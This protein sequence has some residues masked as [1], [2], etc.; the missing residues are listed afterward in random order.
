MWGQRLMPG[1][2]LRLVPEN[3]GVTSSDKEGEADFHSVLYLS[4]QRAAGEVPP[5]LPASWKTTVSRSLLFALLQLSNP[6]WCGNQTVSVKCKH[7]CFLLLVLLLRVEYVTITPD[8]FRYRAQIFP[9]VNGLF[10]W[11]KDHYQEPVPGTETPSLSLFLSHQLGCG[12]HY[13][14]TTIFSFSGVT[15]SNSSRTR[16]PAS[17]NATPANINI[18]GAS[19]SAPDSDFLFLPLVNDVVS[20]CV[21]TCR[22]DAGGQRAASQHDL[23]D[24]QRHQ[25]GH[26]SKPERQHHPGAVGFQSVRLQREHRGR[27]QLVGLSRES[28]WSEPSER[29]LVQI[30]GSDQV[31]V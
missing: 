23:P 25:R 12:V 4:L 11:F 6:D 14:L 10:R 9:S 28:D 31:P 5:G 3:G 13:R 21:S 29:A 16:T 20:P 7:N 26:G 2:A 18:A 30:G 27:G 17:L 24:V 1:A 19:S 22:L 8:G 15:P